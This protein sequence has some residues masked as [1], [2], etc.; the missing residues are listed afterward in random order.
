[1]TVQPPAGSTTPPGEVPR[2]VELLHQLLGGDS[3]S[4]LDC[5]EAE[6]TLEHLR[7]LYQKDPGT[8]AGHL[9]HLQALRAR[10]DELQLQLAE[11][12][13]EEFARVQA[14]HQLRTDRLVAM[15]RILTFL[16]EQ[17]DH[18]LTRRAEALLH[19]G[20][21]GEEREPPTYIL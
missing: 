15:Y 19:P 20:E 18:P 11:A 12:L 1:M 2:L 8:F 5:V 17:P 14:E 4:V 21:T 6:R 9:E 3:P 7:A 13:L 10:H 16:A